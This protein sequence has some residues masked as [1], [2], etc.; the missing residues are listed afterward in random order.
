MGVQ[1]RQPGRKA[2][3]HKDA[4]A[5]DGNVTS[6]ESG[7]PVSPPATPEPDAAEVTPSPVDESSPAK[8]AVETEFGRIVARAREEADLRAGEMADGT[9]R[10]NDW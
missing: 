10:I 4:E 9:K 5:D 6:T 3:T 8:E 2:Q 1:G 7:G